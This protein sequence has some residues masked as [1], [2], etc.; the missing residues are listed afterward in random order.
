MKSVVAALLGLAALAAPV[1]AQEPNPVAAGGALRVVFLGGNPA[2]AV[3]TPA[4][5]TL[6][7]AADLAREL[8]RRLGL[9]VE[10]KPIPGPPQVIEEVA[11]GRADIGFV[12]YEPSRTGTVEFSQTYILVHQTFIVREDS[13]IRTVADIDRAGQKIAGTTNDS[14][15]LYLARTLKNATPLAVENDQDANKKKLMAGEFDAFSGNR[16]RMTTWMREM[17]GTRVLPDNLFSVPQTIVVPKGKP[18]ALAAVN[19]LIDDARASGLIQ[20]SIEANGLIGVEV[21]P[22]GVPRN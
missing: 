22:P 2:Q 8:G 6:G 21:A 17:P 20:K 1:Q 7:P 9:P 14:I 5:E 16:H 10:I 4:G 15:T 18:E 12:A 13:K 11:G 19:K 3:R